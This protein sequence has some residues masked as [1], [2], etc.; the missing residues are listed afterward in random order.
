MGVADASVA[1]AE[2]IAEDIAESTGAVVEKVVEAFDIVELVVVSDDA[3]KPAA[4]TAVA[5]EGAAGRQVAAGQLVAELLVAA[6]AGPAV[7]PACV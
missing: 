1:A 4:E 6:V 7:Q 3:E 2:D 5:A